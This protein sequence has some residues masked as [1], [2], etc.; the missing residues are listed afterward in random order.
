M[1]LTVLWGPPHDS[2]DGPHTICWLRFHFDSPQHHPPIKMLNPLSIIAIADWRGM[3]AWFSWWHR[4]SRSS[5]LQ[6]HQQHLKPLKKDRERWWWWWWSI[7]IGQKVCVFGGMGQVPCWYVKIGCVVPRCSKSCL[8]FRPRLVLTVAC[9]HEK[10][11]IEF[12]FFPFPSFPFLSFPWHSFHGHFPHTQ[13]RT[14]WELKKKRRKGTWF[15]SHSWNPSSHHYQ[16]CFHPF[17]SL[18][19]CPFSNGAICTRHTRVCWS[20]S[21]KVINLIV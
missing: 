14:H 21:L 17:F 20:G 18:F 19:S 11:K 2:W 9:F 16:W 13:T 1:L 8:C 15:S 7:E 12:L 3:Q 4:H 5:H 10:E 6:L